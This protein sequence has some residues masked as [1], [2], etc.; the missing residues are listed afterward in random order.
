M[1]F[2]EFSWEKAKQLAD[3]AVCNINADTNKCFADISER[4]RK[5]EI[6]QKETSLQLEEL[7]EA[8]HNSADTDTA[9]NEAVL[10][11]ALIVLADTIGDFYYFAAANT[12]SPLFEQ[13]QMM[14]DAAISSVQ[15]VGLE[16]IDAC[17]E[18]FDFVLH[19]AESAGLDNSVP[20]GYVIRTLK[21]G[22]IYREEVVRR[23]SVI[24]NKL[25]LDEVNNE[26][27]N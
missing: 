5:I 20:N 21:C 17:N 16:I 14:W 3:A 18:P 24:V 25:T 8:L 13:A 9:D 4:L 10:V 27:G 26:S 2:W 6:T 11:N 22:F 12:E 7:E 23:A 1:A 19:S 15:A